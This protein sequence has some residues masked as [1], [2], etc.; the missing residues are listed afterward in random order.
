MPSPLSQLTCEMCGARV[1][2][3]RRGRCWVCYIRWAE[4]RPVGKGAVSAVCHDRRLDNLRMVEFRSSF[5]PM[6]HNC[7]TKTYRLTPIPQSLEGLTQRLGR[8][9]RWTARRLGKEDTR[10][11]PADR[12]AADRRAVAPVTEEVWEDAEELII[13]A[14]AL[15]SA[16]EHVHELTC[17]VR[18]K[19]ETTNKV[20]VEQAASA[21]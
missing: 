13:E 4:S 17:I 19:R 18:P 3:L 11:R 8:D 6:C 9:R 7:G 10:Q 5:I 15:P 12:R 14:S 16:D 1:A 2:T 21:E 20:R